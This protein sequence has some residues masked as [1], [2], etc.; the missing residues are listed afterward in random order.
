LAQGKTIFFDIE[1]GG[2]KADL[3]SIY[4]ISAQAESGKGIHSQS[5]YANPEKGTYWSQWTKRMIWDRIK[6]KQREETLQITSEKQLLRSF[7]NYLSQQ[8]K[9]TTLAG[10][11]IGLDIREQT[12]TNNVTGYDIPFMLRRAKKYGMHEELASQLSKFNIRDIG[13]EYAY[14]TATEVSKDKLGIVNPELAAGAKKYHQIGMHLRDWGP[15]GASESARLA[16]K[17]FRMAGW[18]Q[19]LMYEVFTGSKL[20]GAHLS[21]IDIQASS[22]LSKS[23]A[24]WNREKLLAWNR[25]AMI[26]KLTASAMAPQKAGEPARWSRVLNMAQEEQ[27]R[28]AG[29][30][31]RS[32]AWTTQERKIIESYSTLSDDLIKNVQKQAGERG[33]SFAD[34]TAGNLGPEKMSKIGGFTRTAEGVVSSGGA[35][36]RV[37]SRVAKMSQLLGTRGKIAVGVGAGVAALWMLEPL[38]SRPSDQ[39]TIEGMPHGG[40]AEYLRKEIT[41]FS[42]PYKGGAVSMSLVSGQV[43]DQKISEAEWRKYV[44]QTRLAMDEQKTLELLS[45][46]EMRKALNQIKWRGPHGIQAWGGEKPT[47]GHGGQY[48]PWDN[49]LT[50]YNRVDPNEMAG[51]YKYMAGKSQGNAIDALSFI[52]RSTNPAYVKATTLHEG[53]HAVWDEHIDPKDK[54]VFMEHA[55]SQLGVFFKGKDV[56]AL[57]AKHPVYANQVRIASLFG[58]DSAEEWVANELFAHRGT[59]VKYKGLSYEFEDNASLDAVVSKYMNKG[60]TVNVTSAIQDFDPRAAISET[61]REGELAK[62]AKKA[63]AFLDNTQ[64]RFADRA[65]NNT[66]RNTLPTSL[67][68]QPIDPKIL[69]FRRDVWDVPGKRR[70]IERQVREAQAEAQAKL[71]KFESEDF[72]AYDQGSVAGIS[73]RRQDLKRINLDNF[74]MNVED[75]DTVLLRRKGMIPWI[76]SALGMG[77]EVS[78]RLAGIDAPET[79]GHGNDPIGFLRMWQEQPGGEEATRKLETILADQD[80]LNLVVSTGK[81]TYGRYLGVLTGD[82]NSN[83]NLE[84][85]EKGAATALPFGPAS[86][87]ILER[88][89]G[90]RAEEVA[91]K[92]REGVWEYARFKA[93]R[94]AH[95]HV[96][97]AIT[98]NTLT[99][100]QKLASN[101]NL[102]AYGSW[103][104]GFGAQK[105]EITWEEIEQAQRF[106][107]SLKRSHGPRMSR[108]SKSR[109]NVR[110]G[111]ETLDGMRYTEAERGIVRKTRMVALTKKTQIEL[112]MAARD[113]ARRHQQQRAGGMVA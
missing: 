36:A 45:L 54:E 51:I 31:Q 68:G 19:E 10:W 88:Q 69:E 59:A 38:S 24:K 57:A 73:S 70:D 86:E 20:E 13:A 44:R 53:L 99:N 56:K 107:R 77:G 11:N 40:I 14:K 100:V 4:S 17:R 75:A 82:Q 106:G 91:W 87:D 15:K 46:H 61:F 58:Q 1:A 27:E 37:S 108:P 39:N 109:E 7:T 33:V 3:S 25:G 47:L 74:V 60:A 104:H 41:D 16:A 93:Q 89:Y 79:A 28:M 95:R 66:T 2:L 71:G 26:N 6:K 5:W 111:R 43:A 83:L 94:V 30:L 32:E 97:R 9:G 101:L 18:K 67:M 42:S 102:G 8:E 103:L 21:D 65:Q 81:Q 63:S 52:Y 49:K 98:H 12:L 92:H 50:V 48:Q 96:G 35:K 34:V 112:A 110:A 76:K 62:Y 84:L 80:N 55:K 29:L 64:R 105:R 85:L 78:I 113:G 72:L 22:V 23:Q 90:A